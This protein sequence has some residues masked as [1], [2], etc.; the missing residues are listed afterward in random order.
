MAAR[1]TVTPKEAAIVV[2][3]W[4]GMDGAAVAPLGGGLINDTFAVTPR[5]GPPVVLQRL[6]PVFS[7]EIHH[8]IATVTER[9]AASGMM[10]PR[11]VATQQGA[12]WATVD[13][14]PWRLMTR[15]AGVTH[16][17]VS[18]PAQ[19]FAAAA[20]LGR[21]HAALEGL[22]PAGFVGLRTGVHDTEGHLARLAAAVA[23]G[24]AH[25]L[26]DRVAPLAD[27]L[28]ERAQ[29]LPALPSAPP[30]I[31]HGDPKLNNVVFAASQGDPKAR[32]WIDLDTVG[33]M[34]LAYELGDAW[35]SWCNPAG[36]NAAAASFDAA[37]FEASLA[38][39]A[40]A[41]VPP[42]TA[43]EREGLLHGVEWITLELSARFLAD[44]LL[45]SYFGW[46]P[47]RFASR[48]DH[49]L[50]RARSQWSMHE[51]VLATRT[52]RADA[53]RRSLGA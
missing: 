43:A 17:T 2:Q 38:G 3:A 20:L 49:N 9:L 5:D 6:H 29:Q 32:A 42:P 28:L 39:W 12:L 8:N 10:T 44:A 27:A 34:P 51:C 15:V 53:L 14:E 35:R 22:D 37:V 11:I 25:R 24:R 26:H 4:P 48:G 36:E 46:D 18:S 19:A 52:L 31:V 50:A 40:S 7:P 23:E 1:A 47:T 33:P 45:E 30:R 16:D 41:V 21:F 13:D